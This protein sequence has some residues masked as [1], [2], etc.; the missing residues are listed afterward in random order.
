MLR[1]K[2]LALLIALLIPACA[3]PSTQP[4]ATSTLL[5]KLPRVEN[6][7]S[8]PCWQQQQIAKQNSYLDTL[9]NNKETV[10]KAACDVEKKVAKKS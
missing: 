3:D 2:A 7:R 8:S 9:K 4:P 10:W 6:S 5:D 1:K